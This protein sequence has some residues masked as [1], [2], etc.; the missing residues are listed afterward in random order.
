MQVKRYRDGKLLDLRASEANWLVEHGYAEAVQA[1]AEAPA[2]PK[3]AS[4]RKPK[5]TTAKPEP[6][7]NGET[8][9]QRDITEGDEPTITSWSSHS[10]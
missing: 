10:E 6:A 3:R 9:T 5:A 4:T 1:E 8:D 2:K 7:T